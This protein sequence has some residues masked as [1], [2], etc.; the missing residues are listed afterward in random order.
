MVPRMGSSECRC[1][2]WGVYWTLPSS[3][4]R[5]LDRCMSLTHG[6]TLAKTV[7]FH[8]VSRSWRLTMC[9]AQILLSN[10]MNAQRPAYD[11]RASTSSITKGDATVLTAPAIEPK[12]QN[13]RF[14]R[15]SLPFIPSHDIPRG[16]LHAGQAALEF[17]FMLA[18]MYA[19]FSVVSRSR[20]H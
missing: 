17:S 13:S 2:G 14:G 15:L 1:Y 16:I 5:S 18:V 6:G 19:H 9:R 20:A 12:R 3:T 7:C 10:K 11:S 8:T 4:C